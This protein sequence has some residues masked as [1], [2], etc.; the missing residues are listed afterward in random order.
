MKN[1]YYFFSSITFLQLYISIVIE[2]NKKKYNSIFIVR[3]NIKDYCN[4]IFEENF[5]ILQKYSKLYSFT[6]KHK[7]DIDFNKLEG[8]LFLVDG[9]IYGPPRDEIIN[10][11][12]LFLV[13]NNKKLK[14][15]SLTEHMNFWDVYHFFIDHVDYC[16][17]SNENIINQMKN[18]NSEVKI[19]SITPIINTSKNYKNKKNIFLGNTK[20]DNIPDKDTIY[21]KFK[22]N[23]NDK[24]VLFLY[25]KLRHNFTKG[26]ILNIYKH[27]KKM[28][29]KIIIKK[30]PKDKEID[31]DLKGDLFVNSDIYPNESLELMKIS[32]LCIISNS[33][34]NEETI[35]SEIPCLELVSDKRKYNRNEY[36]INDKVYKKVEMNIWKNI[37][38]NDF[39]KL[40]DS[41]DKKYSNTFKNMKKKY[42]FTHN[43]SA[44]KYIEF[45]SL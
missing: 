9:D 16:F 22:L 26:E 18:F 44:K 23:S 43:N 7:N 32:E 38:F 17:F 30:R 37:K 19:N 33:S 36:L 6:I 42:I 14:K 13:K 15:I 4:P 28:N 5:S 25:P 10:E 34:A 8:I 27:L 31:N 45:L 29:F 40:V 20:Y 21:K 12:M 39:K 3:E 41:L 35:I 11:S 24:Y 1:I 2:L